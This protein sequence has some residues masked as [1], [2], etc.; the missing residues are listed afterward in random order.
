MTVKDTESDLPP[1]RKNR[2]QK[3]R[4]AISPMREQKLGE[5]CSDSVDRY[6]KDKL[7]KG[8]YNKVN[9]NTK[10]FDDFGNKNMYLSNMEK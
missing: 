9:G 2:Y 10:L 6:V 5:V 7:I 1:S 3:S 4:H 8:T